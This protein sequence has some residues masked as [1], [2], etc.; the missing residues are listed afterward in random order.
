MENEIKEI[1]QNYKSKIPED[2]HIN[3][4]SGGIIDSFDIVNIVSLFE[5]R[6]NV[7]IDAEDILPENFQSIEAMSK[8][9]GKY[10]KAE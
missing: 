5:S 2:Y 3:L 10:I 4:L 6:F 7:S 1:L 9:V 8:L